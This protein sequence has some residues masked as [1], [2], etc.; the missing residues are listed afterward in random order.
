MDDTEIIERA[1]LGV[2]IP[3]DLTGRMSGRFE[4]FDELQVTDVECQET[5]ACLVSM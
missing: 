5:T 4:D 1:I 3:S 2:M